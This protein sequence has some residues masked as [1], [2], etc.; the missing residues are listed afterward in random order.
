MAIVHAHI[1]HPSYMSYDAWIWHQPS[2]LRSRS[3]H[4]K[5]SIWSCHYVAHT[6]VGGMSNTTDQRTTIPWFLGQW[7]GSVRPLAQWQL[8]GETLFLY[9]CMDVRQG[10]GGNLWRSL[11][12]WFVRRMMT[13]GSI[14]SIAVDS[15]RPKRRQG[16][17][18][19][20]RT[21]KMDGVYRL[22][23]FMNNDWSRMSRCKRSFVFDLWPN[24]LRAMLEPSILCSF[25]CTMVAFR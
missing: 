19:V 15:R 5:M 11:Q 2:M 20:R 13:F 10:K 16:L 3:N 24:S 17:H 4:R 23:N 6:K 12:E 7:V 21:K 22:T 1:C 9:A 8:E 14:A 25:W 18:E